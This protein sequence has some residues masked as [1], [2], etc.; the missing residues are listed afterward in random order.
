MRKRRTLSR[1]RNVVGLDLSAAQ[2]VDPAS[3]PW[4]EEFAK[5]YYEMR[6]H[7]G[8]TLE[9]A[10]DTVLD[11]SYFGTMMVQTGRAD[12]MVS[13]AVHT[14]QHTI[15]PAFEIV[16]TT[17]GCPIVSSVFFMCLPDR[18]L[19]AAATAEG[20][21]SLLTLVGTGYEAVMASFR[22]AFPG[23]EVTRVAESSAG[24]WLAQVRTER[25]TGHH[26]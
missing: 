15:R 6:K 23:I 13:G 19:V 7:K 4:R 16:K 9:S 10:L 26:P 2:V 22:E 17:P 8:A 21:L 11:V 18:V 14:T 12:G 1:R 5:A 24:V 25:R 20:Q 3:S